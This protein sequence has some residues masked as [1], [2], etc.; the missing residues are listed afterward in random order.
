MATATTEQRLERL[1]QLTAYEVRNCKAC[2]VQLYFVRHNTGKAA[3]YT[4]DGVNHFITCPS[5]DSFR[6][7][8]KAEVA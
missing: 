4:A 8:K 7:S 2:G 3:P 6:S 1:L 5:A